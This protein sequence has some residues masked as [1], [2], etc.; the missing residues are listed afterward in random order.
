MKKVFTITI[1]SAM[2]LFAGKSNAQM[3]VHLGFAPESWANEN[4]TTDVNSF[5]VGV[6]D[7]LVLTITLVGL[8]IPVLFNYNF[9]LGSNVS[10]G[11]F[12]GP[13]LSY[14]FV[15]KT[16]YE[17][18]V[19]GLVS[20]SSEVEWFDDKAGA[21]NLKPFNLSATFGLAI[22]YN[23]FRIYGGYNY[24]LLDVDNNDNIK[25]TVSGPFFG[26]GMNL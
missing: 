24:G 23:Q 6:E 2:L 10:L 3:G 18:N 9:K 14:S 25:T 16:K 26:I 13:K 5:F 1:L 11:L 4:N 19:L 12:A 17:G 7:N 22:S 15:G 20:G 21:L 8:D